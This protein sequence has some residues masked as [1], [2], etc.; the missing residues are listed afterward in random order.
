MNK[1]REELLKENEKLKSIIRE[2]KEVF[3]FLND[4]LGLESAAKSN[5]FIAKVGV[6]IS[7]VQRNPQIFDKVGEY[8]KKLNEINV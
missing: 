7:K 5:F 6:I 8:L 1:T 3:T 2:G 4:T